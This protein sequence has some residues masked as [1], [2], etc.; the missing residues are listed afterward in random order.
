LDKDFTYCR[1]LRNGNNTIHHKDWRQEY[2]NSQSDG[3]DMC[4]SEYNM[5]TIS[6]THIITAFV[7]ASAITIVILYIIEKT[8]RDDDHYGG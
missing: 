2:E 6:A 3:M 8:D 1:V 4:Y 5:I 7:I